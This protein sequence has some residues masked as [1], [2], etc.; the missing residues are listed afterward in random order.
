MSEKTH[1][2]THNTHS[3]VFFCYPLGAL[4]WKEMN[5]ENEEEEKKAH[6]NESVNRTVRYF[7][8]QENHFPYNDSILIWLRTK[9][10]SKKT[11]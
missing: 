5:W 11:K 1:T 2:H 6:K 3:K 10:V 7:L 9:H 8:F 4:K